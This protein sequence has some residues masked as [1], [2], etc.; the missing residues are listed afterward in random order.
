MS[1]AC[2]LTVPVENFCT[3]SCSRWTQINRGEPIKIYHDKDATYNIP[4]LPTHV[5]WDPNFYNNIT[6]LDPSVYL[7]QAIQTWN[8]A[9]PCGD[10]FEQVDDPAIA[11][12][13]FLYQETGLGSPNPDSTAMGSATCFCEADD[14]VN[15]CDRHVDQSLRYIPNSTPGYASINFYTPPTGNTGVGWSTVAT[16]VHTVMHELGHILGFGHTFGAVDA[17]GNPAYSIM[18]TWDPNL[19]YATVQQWDQDKIETRY[20][21]GGPQGCTIIEEPEPPTPG[22]GGGLENAPTANYCPGCQA[23]F[24]L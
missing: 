7:D 24:L 21:C 8:D 16:Y 15:G 9:Y 11:Q 6:A 1:I 17:N 23:T 4:G 19:P 18:G 10:L 14:L 20:P 3:A 13:I 2:P 12:V 5:P 22:G